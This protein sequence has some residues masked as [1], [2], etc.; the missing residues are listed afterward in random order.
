MWDIIAGPVAP[1]CCT[2]AA[3][4]CSGGGAQWCRA[5]EDSWA[6]PGPGREWKTREDLLESWQT[7]TVPV[8]GLGEGRPLSA[9]WLCSPP[10]GWPAGVGGSRGCRGSRRRSG[11]SSSQI[12]SPA[13]PELLH[14]RSHL[15]T[16]YNFQIICSAE[17]DIV[18][19]GCIIKVTHKSQCNEFMF[20]YQLR[21]WRRERWKRVYRTFLVL[22]LSN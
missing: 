2:A 20:M 19:L 11:W 22:L 4:G 14:S 13:L 21:L 12:G 7:A 16:K 9:C 8:T 15:N 5:G 1:W 3:A 18:D 6:W 10:P 17:N